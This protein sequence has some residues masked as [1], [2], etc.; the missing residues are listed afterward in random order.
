MVFY[1][2]VNQKN[3]FFRFDEYANMAA[4]STLKP[5][6]KEGWGMVENIANRANFEEV[7]E[8]RRKQQIKLQKEVETAELK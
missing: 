8:A 7:R 6:E 5:V 3:S 4:I 2:Q 1:K